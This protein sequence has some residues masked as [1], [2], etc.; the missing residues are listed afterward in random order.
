MT[1]YRNYIPYSYDYNYD[2][3]YYDDMQ[4]SGSRDEIWLN[5]VICEFFHEILKDFQ[6]VQKFL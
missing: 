4:T 3:Y 1:D 6:A 2:Q 5:V